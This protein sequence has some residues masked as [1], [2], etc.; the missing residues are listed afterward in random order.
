M[1]F[2]LQVLIKGVSIGVLYAIAATGFV[3]IFQSSR[4]LNFA[5]GGLMAMGA[6]LFLVL[7]SWGVPIV[8][9]FVLTLSGTFAIGLLL[10][11]G[12]HHS[13]IESSPVHGAIL[14]IGLALIFKSLFAFLS[15]ITL[16][17]YSEQSC[18]ALSVNLGEVPIPGFSVA[19]FIVG[20][21]FFLF[22]GLF[23]KYSSQGIY[24]RSTI[25]NRAAAF[26]LG[27]PVKRM[28]ALSWAIAAMACA[29]TGIA[30]GI[31]NKAS[32]RDLGFIGL[33]IFP[34]VVLGGLSSIG[35]A[36]LGGI[37]IGV[38]EALTKGYISTSFGEI[39]PY[40]ALFVMIALKPGGFIGTAEIKRSWG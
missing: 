38:L 29:I 40:I 39:I 10:E 37:L 11:K 30:L 13:F 28:L 27:V 9:C 15:E 34:V 24:M 5:H 23:F 7:S 36:I 3:M 12:L 16:H 33:K 8:F 26:A 22:F 20:F 1:D 21:L 19:V 17:G 4:V 6:F 14:T 35:G 32:F 2:F 31:V 25:E 18:K